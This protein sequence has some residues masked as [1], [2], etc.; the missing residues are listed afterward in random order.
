MTVV[1][2]T[3][4][5]LYL[6]APLFSEAERQFNRQLQHL[7]SSYFELYVPQEHGGLFAEMVRGGTDPTEAA[8]RIFSWDI[9]AIGQCDLILIVLDGRTVDEGAAFEVGYGYAIGKLCYGLQTDPRRLV[10]SGNN[11]MIEQA[12]AYIF[13]GLEELADWARQCQMIRVST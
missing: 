11:P 2:Q 3:R 6:A 1:S 10:P 13:H 4:S 5:R 8:R 12:L 7:L 9:T